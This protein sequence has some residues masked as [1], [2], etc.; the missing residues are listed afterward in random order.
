MDTV[1]LRHA[2]HYSAPPAVQCEF[3]FTGERYV[4]NPPAIK[5][6]ALP[7]LT[8]YAAPDGIN[9][10]TARVSIPKMLYGNNVQMVSGKEISRALDGISNYASEL[11]GVEFDA[12]SANVGQ[13]DFS[14]NFQVGEENA[15]G[16]L[17]ALRQTSM[18][19]MKRRIIGDGETVDFGN[20]SQKVICYSKS[21]ETA[22][23]ARLS[24]ATDADVRAAV[25]ILRVEHRFL[26]S[27]AC[28]RLAERFNLPDRRADYLLRDDIAEMVM[29]ETIMKLGLDKAVESG[30]SRLSLL[31]EHCHGY[32]SRFQ[33]LA[34]FLAL[35]D[36]YGAD[37]LVPLRIVTERTFYR[38]RKE[39]EEAGAWLVSPVK[40]TLPPLRLVRSQSTAVGLRS[41]IG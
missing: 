17:N 41:A 14:Y 19:R 2:Y 9:Y 22:N 16:Y 33:R 10:L 28:K 27:G 12:K 39:V 13:I 32:G 31:R 40:R 3:T 21:V 25:G 5:N 11:S 26:N 29:N 35:C 4:F 1:L 36:A 24:K 18:P 23:L 38:Q 6:H 15:F 8:W 37:N 30:D 34:G 7:A 20:R